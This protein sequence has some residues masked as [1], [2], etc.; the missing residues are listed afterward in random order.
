MHQAVMGIEGR[1]VGGFYT[2]L[3]GG[4]EEMTCWGPFTSCSLY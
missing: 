3:N 2:T 1:C 4:L